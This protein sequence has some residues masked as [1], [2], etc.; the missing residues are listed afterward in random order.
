[1][2]ASLTPQ[3]EKLF[4]GFEHVISMSQ[5]IYHC[6]KSRPQILGLKSTFKTCLKTNAIQSNKKMFFGFL[7]LI[8]TVFFELDLLMNIYKLIL[9][10]IRNFDFIMSGFHGHTSVCIILCLLNSVLGPDLFWS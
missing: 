7:G 10:F 1:M 2:Y 4:L 9:I 6:F 5:S 8:I 3:T